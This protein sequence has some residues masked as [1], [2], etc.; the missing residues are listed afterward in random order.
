MFI[1]TV[2]KLLEQ[3]CIVRVEQVAHN[4]GNCIRAALFQVHT[5]GVWQIIQFFGGIENLLPL[6]FG[7]TDLP[8][9]K[10]L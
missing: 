8:V 4:H 5:G 9:S 3:L 10:N 2:G 6:C 1:Q 7:N